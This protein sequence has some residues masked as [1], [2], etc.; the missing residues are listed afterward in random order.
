MSV[1]AITSGAVIVMGTN[2]GIRAANAAVQ[3][4]TGDW[5]GIPAYTFVML[6]IEQCKIY[7][8]LVQILVVN[9]LQLL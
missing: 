2:V 8:V 7:M 3:R 6:V 1:Y 4:T 9:Q 5:S